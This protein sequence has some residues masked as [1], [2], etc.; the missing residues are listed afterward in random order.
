MTE[1]A[2]PWEI[3]PSGLT[4][5]LTETPP[6]VVID[7][8]ETIER[9]TCSIAGTIHIPMGDVPSRLPE[10]EDHADS[11]VVV[12]CHHGVRSL[13]VVAFLKEAGFT[14]VRSLAGGIDRWSIEIDP[15]IP[16]Y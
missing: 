9:E 4:G 14:N 5:L 15:T 2:H 11:P 3:E 13:Q 6:P 1:S 12:Y 8:R 10:L 16:R 7:C